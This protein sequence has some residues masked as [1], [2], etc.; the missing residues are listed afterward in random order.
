METEFKLDTFLWNM[1]KE[2]QEEKWRDVD[3]SLQIQT[4]KY[5]DFAY[6]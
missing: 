6:L 5:C 3:F 4:K 2:I 1:I